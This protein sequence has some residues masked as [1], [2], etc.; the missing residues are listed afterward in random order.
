[1][2]AGTGGRIAAGCISGDAICDVQYH[3]LFS[4]MIPEAEALKGKIIRPSVFMSKFE[5]SG[6]PFFL[7]INLWAGI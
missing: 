7:K 2:E 1:M 3:F 4:Y 6:S 5:A